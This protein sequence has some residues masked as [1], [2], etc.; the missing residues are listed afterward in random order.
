MI[1]FLS[2]AAILLLS[3]AFAGAQLVTS[4]TIDKR[5]YVAGEGIIAE[6]IVTNHSGRP[7]TL[8]S[9]RE[10]PW[11]AIVVTNS[12][13]NPVPTRRLNAFGAMKIKAGESLAKRVNLNDYFLL[14]TQGNYAVS[15]V[16][17]DPQ[18]VVQGSSTNRVLFNLNPG[19]KYW[20]Q[21]IGVSSDSGIGKREF[22][23]LTFIDKQAT[24]LYVQLI[25][26]DTGV[27]I[28]TFSLGP[29]LMMRKP[30]VT[31]DGK[32]RMHVMY[33]GTPAIWVHSQITADGKLVKRDLYQR[34]SQGDPLLMAYGDG[35]V[36]VMNGVLY[37]PK[38]E[39]KQQET[40][41]K[42]SDRPPIDFE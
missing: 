15:A 32:Q 8:A 36:R 29:A 30:L 2:V 19:R 22:R 33:L 23:L 39:Q 1:R 37:N 13:G 4:L 17:R 7:L 42:A 28:R 31:V 20:S 16:V 25:D 14:E 34:A 10:L 9:S 24:H 6:I 3:T 27:Q 21:Q 40:I 41:R 11:L 5:T 18:G 38:A 12:Q 26:L 35:T